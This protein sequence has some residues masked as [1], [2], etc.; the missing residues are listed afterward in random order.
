MAHIAR[1]VERQLY[2]QIKMTTNQ[3]TLNLSGI[4]FP[5][6]SRQGDNLNLSGIRIP[7]AGK[8]GEGY[9]MRGKTCQLADLLM[10]Q[11]F[12][13]QNLIRGSL[14]LEELRTKQ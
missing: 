14:N 12:D 13:A 4:G 11:D 6:P 2:S 9:I 7:G 1:K 5:H 8:C 10:M 3:L